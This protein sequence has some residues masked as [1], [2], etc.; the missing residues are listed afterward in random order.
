MEACLSSGEAA[1]WHVPTEHCMQR[2]QHNISGLAGGQTAATI[3][4]A[5][6]GALHLVPAAGCCLHL[7]ADSLI[8]EG[9]W[10]PWLHKNASVAMEAGHL[11]TA[12]LATCTCPCEQ[13]L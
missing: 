10:F 4:L 5:L 8:A 11:A 13:C 1:C 3:S 12:R 7:P 9:A 2:L 6:P